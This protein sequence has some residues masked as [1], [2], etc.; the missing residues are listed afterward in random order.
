MTVPTLGKTKD[1]TLM[2][3]AQVIFLERLAIFQR[4]EAKIIKDLGIQPD[5]VKLETNAVAVIKRLQQMVEKMKDE[6][7]PF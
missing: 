3:H 5:L 2:K 6:E 1:L 4:D 7:V